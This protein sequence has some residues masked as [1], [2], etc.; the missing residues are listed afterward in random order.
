MIVRFKNKQAI[1]NKDAWIANNASIIGEVKID[2]LASIWFNSV[3]RADLNYISI[4]HHTNIQDGTI[5]HVTKALP[6]V[7]GNYV[8]VG[9]GAILHGC[10]V[11]DNTLIGSG[12]NILDDVKI[13]HNVIIAAG[14]VVTPNTDIP[15][16]SMVMGIP[17]KV[18]KKLTHQDAKKLK[19]H[20]LHY[21]ALMKGY[22]KEG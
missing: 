3:L 7:I 14:S 11:R 9:H 1:I 13:G 2:Y 4:G 15:D 22:Q 12:A 5:I 8:T 6:T 19:N 10:L 21:V 20:A 16:N 18:V 17:G